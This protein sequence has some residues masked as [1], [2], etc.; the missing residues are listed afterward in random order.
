M[1]SD[2]RTKAERLARK[3]SR[4]GDRAE[5]AHPLAKWLLLKVAYGYP[6]I[7]LTRRATVCI[8]LFLAAADGPGFVV[9]CV[10]WHRVMGDSVTRAAGCVVEGTTML[11]PNPNP[12]PNHPEKSIERRDERNFL[13]HWF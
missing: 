10:L 6:C 9:G 3:V 13:V 2:E 1:G 4:D 7:C 5:F 12:N 8:F 11:N